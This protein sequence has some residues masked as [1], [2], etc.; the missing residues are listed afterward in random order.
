M[1]YLLSLLLCASCFAVDSGEV[2]KN[3]NGLVGRWL[4]PGHQTGNGGVPSKVLD[5]YRFHNDG[6][7]AGG[8]TYGLTGG[9]AAMAFN[10]SSQY[11]DLGSNQ[12]LSG[13]MSISLWVNPSSSAGTGPYVISNN[14][15]INKNLYYL[16]VSSVGHIVYGWR[17]DNSGIQ[18]SVTVLAAVTPDKWSHVVAVTN[19][20]DGTGQLWV[21]GIKVN[22]SSVTPYSI[23]TIQT[24]IRFGAHSWDPVGEF[25]KGSLADICIYNRVLSAAE[26]KALYQQGLPQ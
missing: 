9:R 2:R 26:I 18:K 3:D 23:G 17:Y 10:G 22:D 20:A 21:N 5:A 13:L 19:P 25:F 12:P 4:V 11:V 16:Q 14:N 6:T 1:R 24:P 7:V 8:A 15:T